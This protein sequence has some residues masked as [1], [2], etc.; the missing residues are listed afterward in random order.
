MTNFFSH[1]ELS[2][3]NHKT[4]LITGANGMLGRAFTELIRALIPTAHLFAA[5]KDILDVTDLQSVKGYLSI[6]PDIIIHCAAKVNADYC[7]EHEDE[8]FDIIVTGTRNILELAK[9]TGATVFFPQS[10][11]IYDG[12]EQPITELTKPNPLSAYGRL[13]LMAENMLFKELPD[14]L[15]VRMAGFFGGWEADKNFV[16]KIIP[17][18][19]QLIR[20]GCHALEIGDRIWQPTYTNDLAFNSLVLLSENKSGVYCM[21]S[22]GTASFFDLS[23]VIVD[24]LGIGNRLTLQKVSSVLV[25]KNEKALRPIAAII[26]NRRLKHDNLDF[27]RTWQ[28]SITEYLDHPYFTN[29]FR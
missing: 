16:G 19:S 15:V 17:R 23:S 28:E 10:F 4:I 27:Q 9:Q 1:R 14:S 26:E 3:L 8:A 25:S 21:A 22:K 12:R 5:G 18:M 29:M 7:E 11:L 20:E 6:N 13:K 2:S 24:A